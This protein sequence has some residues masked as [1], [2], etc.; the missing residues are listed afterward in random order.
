MKYFHRTTVDPGAVMEEADSFFGSRLT[1]DVQE[2]RNRMFSGNLGSLALSVRAEGG[3]YTNVTAETD[4]PGESELDKLV[5]RFFAT[6]HK[7]TEPSHELRGA[8]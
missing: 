5:K 6:V 7:K 2:D 1:T 3:H 8:Y 4:R